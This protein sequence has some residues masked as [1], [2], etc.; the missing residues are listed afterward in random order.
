MSSI[1]G[2]QTL[3]VS[4]LCLA[5]LVGL[6]AQ[7]GDAAAPPEPEVAQVSHYVVLW[8]DL[9]AEFDTATDTIKRQMKFKH[10]VQHGVQILHDKKTA[11]AITGQ[12][13]VIEVIDLAKLETVDEHPIQ[14]DGWI[15]RVRSIMEC[16]GGK[17]WW[18]LCERVEKKVDHFVI[19]EQAWF[20]YDLGTKE[21]G[22][23]MK[24]LPEPI[25]R[26]ARISPDG[27]AWHV[28]DKDVVVLDAETL[29][30]T[31]RI[32]LSKPLFTGMGAITLQSQDFH[33][34][35]RS[36][37]YRMLWSMTDPVNTNRRL[38]GIIDLDMKSLRIA[39]REE[40]GV[41]SISSFGSYITADHK[42]AFGHGGGRRGFGGRGGTGGES[43]V[44]LAAWDLT[45]GQR[46]A[47]NTFKARTAL[48]L[49]AITADG[50]KLY[51]TG[52][53]HDVLVVSGELKPVR[54]LE[55]PG[56]VSDFIEIRR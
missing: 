6:A 38:G 19:H 33:E 53:G 17:K 54:T 56:E 16:P 37:A 49:S 8:P 43:E 3:R 45:N 27:T 10:G 25:R 52:R 23:S 14:K 15:L 22:E 32:E 30:E 36:D 4:S 1:A 7:D 31:G 44:S 40:W 39:R 11:L 28:F 41:P 35:R 42:R 34:G 2:L 47:E 12:R 55:L 13:G 5:L 48:G 29:K 21:L 9:F 20:S 51:L 50:S 18:V 24:E 26:G 46:V